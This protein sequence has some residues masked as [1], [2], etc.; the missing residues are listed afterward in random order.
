M[1]RRMSASVPARPDWMY[2]S[3]EVDAAVSCLRNAL[4]TLDG[5]RF[6]ATH[7]EPLFAVLAT[8]A[9]KLLKLTYGLSAQDETGTWPSAE[10]MGMGRGG[11]GHQLTRLDSECRERM[12][13][14][15]SEAAAPGYLTALL[16]ELDAAP[17]LA[18]LLRALE[19]YAREG[20]FHNLDQLSKRENISDAPLTLW[21]S[22]YSSVVRD[23]P[24]YAELL[25]GP[26]ESFEELRRRTNER[27]AATVWQWWETY[28]RAWVQGVCGAQAKRF[29]SALA[30]PKR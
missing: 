3:Y 21:Q 19:R 17:Y 26:P 14:G 25:G 30:P 6:A 1:L 15:L 20:R 4:E 29:G 11:F 23:D 28:H 12:R 9:E 7:A 10:V 13:A 24:D 2:L 5:Y 22:L 16:G 18:D 27:L 8:G